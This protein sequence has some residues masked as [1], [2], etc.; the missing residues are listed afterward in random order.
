MD[1]LLIIAKIIVPALEVGL[2][3]VLPGL[4]CGLRRPRRY[5]YICAAALYGI[6]WLMSETHLG[7]YKTV[8]WVVATITTTLLLY[9]GKRWHRVLCTIICLLASGVCDQL[10][11]VFWT[12]LTDVPDYATASIATIAPAIISKI[13]AWM[14]LWGA[15]TI[16]MRVTRR[17]PPKA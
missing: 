15:A 16:I 6:L 10:A 8:V 2:V 5:I 11:L 1:I 17:R 9:G 4:M 14:I 3:F 12:P 7:Y 13:V